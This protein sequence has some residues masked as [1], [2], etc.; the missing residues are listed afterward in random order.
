MIHRDSSKSPLYHPAVT[1]FER[2]Y[3]VVHRSINRV[4]YFT[5]EFSLNKNQPVSTLT[6]ELGEYLISYS[7]GTPPFKVY[8]FMDTGSNI[9]WLQCQPCHTCFNQTSPIF[10]PSK[11]SS[12]KNIPC[13]SSTCKDTNETH[14][15]CSNGG[16][17]CEYSITY[18]GDAKSQGDLSNDSLTLDSTS[19]SSVLFPNIVI[20]CGHINVLQ[21]NSQSSGV[22][23][24][25][26]GPMSLIKQVSSSSVGSKFS[27][28]LIPYNSDSN[29]SS[30]L[31]FGEDVVVSG[32]MVVSTPMVKVNGQEN[33]Y[34]LTL[35]A[36]SV[37]NNRIEYG[38][39]S[40]ASTQNILIDS[41]TP[42]TRLPN[43]F[44]SKFVSYVAQEIKLPR[45]EPPDHHLSLCYN[46][47]G[48]QLNVPDITAHFNGAD[49]KLN[50]NGTF[51][52]FEEGIM[53][54][55]FISS[56]GLEIFGNIAQNNLLIGY[57]LEKEI[58]SFKP[59]DCTKY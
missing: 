20:G 37:G 56:N 5:K 3:N 45:I 4:N 25:G 8:G 15:S 13:T 34:F 6:P 58:I 7:V 1:K 49:V 33:Y 14:I 54:F 57:D 52:P 18:G 50:S 35:E 41:G 40:N 16:D 53:C 11:S 10:N 43:L 46:T 28:C 38:E 9:V 31:I 27:Y 32:E 2:A 29:S 59:T 22:V 48:K 30:K 42:L 12:Y 55:G 21:D 23:G 19:G 47:T 24:M 17:V 51:F 36:F 26:R 44:L 39:R